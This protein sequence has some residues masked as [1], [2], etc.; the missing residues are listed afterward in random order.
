MIITSTYRDRGVSMRRLSRNVLNYS[1][2]GGYPS[3][4]C[5]YYMT[6]LLASK[7]KRDVTVSLLFRKYSVTITTSAVFN[8]TTAYTSY[9]GF[10]VRGSKCRRFGFFFSSLLIFQRYW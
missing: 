8:T 5:A 10:R 2:M 7:E 9:E 4:S 1:G 6:V 3:Y